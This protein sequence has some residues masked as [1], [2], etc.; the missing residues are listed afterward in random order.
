MAYQKLQHI[1]VL[2]LLQSRHLAIEIAEASASILI[3][4][5]SVTAEMHIAEG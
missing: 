5:A 3:W 2:R 4:K 1:D